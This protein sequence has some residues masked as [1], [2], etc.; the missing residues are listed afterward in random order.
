MSDAI[1]EVRHLSK[2]FG[3]NEVLRDIDFDVQ[4]QVTVK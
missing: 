3:S 1:L 2:N 4:V